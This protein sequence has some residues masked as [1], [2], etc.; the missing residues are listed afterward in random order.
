GAPDTPYDVLIVA[1]LP[2]SLTSIGRGENAGRK[3][4]E[5]NIVRDLRV[6]GRWD[7]DNNRFSMDMTSLST[8]ATRAAVLLQQPDQGPI[9]GATIISLR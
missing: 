4:K 8:E 9:V 2:Q 1:Y 6:L 7:A 5:T 3:L